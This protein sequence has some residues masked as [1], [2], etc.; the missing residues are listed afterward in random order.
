MKE[1][2]FLIIG[3]AL[4]LNVVLN[5][6]NKG[7]E[8]STE[9]QNILDKSVDNKKVFGT[10]FC[11]KFKGE[12]WCGSAGNIENGQ[13]Y[14]IASTTKLFVT[15]IIL[16]FVSEKK[17]ALDDKISSYLDA[18]TMQ[19]LH[20]FKGADYSN[21]I[22]VRN[23]L[24]HT[25]GLP[26]YF[27]D[28][29]KNGKSLQDEL[30]LGN[31]QSWTFDQ[32]IERSKK[33]EPIFAPNTKNKAHYSDA[34]FQ[35]LGKIIENITGQ[36]FSEKCEELII[37][38]LKLTNTY[39]YTDISDTKPKTMYY[40]QN[41]LLIPR[42][43]SSFRADGGMVSTSEDLLIFIEAFFS[44]QLFPKSYIVD[45][46]VWNAI[47]PPLKSGIGILLFKLPKILGI[48]ELI[49]H[50]GLSGALAYY[51]PKNDLYVSGTVNQ[52]AHP[53]TSFTVT[54]KLIKTTL[55]EQKREKD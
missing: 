46:Q 14:F 18:P 41:E 19:D 24:A 2:V 23:L 55:V 31:D 7:S 34:N 44:G 33:M 6:Q 27:E 22:T 26:D 28:K 5:A 53:S 3:M 8:K 29:D 45:L 25:S 37:K 21:E 10:A 16:Q 52:I 15:A 38:P 50:S 20:I 49:G 40:K 43:M 13:P 1:L 12:V 11:V 47:F 36:S 39:I 32:A 9:L 48:P 4:S 35:L 51:D 30:F 54:T 17:I 42:A